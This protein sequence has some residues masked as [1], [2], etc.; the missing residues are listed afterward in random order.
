MNDELLEPSENVSIELKHKVDALS[1]VDKPSFVAG[2]ALKATVKESLKKELVAITAEKQSRH[3]AYK[4]VVAIESKIKSRYQDVLEPLDGKLHAFVK[5]ENRIAAEAAAK[6]EAEARKQAE[7]ARLAQAAELE[8]QGKTEEAD[9]VV[10]AP[11]PVPAIK[12][13][14]MMKVKGAKKI[15]R[16]DVTDKAAFVKGCIEGTGVLSMDCFD[17]NTTLIGSLVVAQKE[18]FSAPGITTR[19]DNSR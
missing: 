3:T 13:A 6:A 9:A 11:V 4:K 1:V 8:K 2:E 15:W 18:K 10:S 14:P 12:A 7:E 16:F 19:V 5:E 17:V